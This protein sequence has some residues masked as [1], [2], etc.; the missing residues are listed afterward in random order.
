[1]L[2]VGDGINDAPALRAASVS[3]ALGSGS[4]LAQASADLVALRGDLSALPEAVRL[5]RRTTRVIRQNL[6]WSAAY[7]LVALP[8]AALGLVPPW[9]AAVGMSASSLLVVLNALRLARRAPVA[10]APP[11]ASSRLPRPAVAA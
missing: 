8:V 2:A 1:V 5:A 11:T 7:N 10:A 4:A 6:A 9:L 3:L